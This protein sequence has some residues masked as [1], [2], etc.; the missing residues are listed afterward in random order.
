MG[1]SNV[2]HKS[3]IKHTPKTDFKIMLESEKK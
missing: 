3:S 2:M 1:F